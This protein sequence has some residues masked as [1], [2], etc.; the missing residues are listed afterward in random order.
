MGSTPFE[1]KGS[2][3]IEF[4]RFCR[5]MGIRPS[6]HN[7]I[8]DSDPQARAHVRANRVH[9]KVDINSVLQLQQ[10]IKLHNPYVVIYRLAKER[11]DSEDHISLCLKTVDASHLDQRRY[12]HPTAS[13]VVIIM[14]GNGEDGATERHL[15][16]QPLFRSI[17]YFKRFF[18]PLRYP[19]FVYGE[20]GWHPNIR[21]GSTLFAHTASTEF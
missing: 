15:V 3:A 1:Y 12:N 2:S 13:E 8:Y 10:M 9:D 18:I 16:V 6:S 11:L 21:L 5:Q 17:S 4:P 20:Q 14:V 19:I 7:S